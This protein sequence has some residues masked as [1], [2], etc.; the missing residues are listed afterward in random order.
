M[1]LQILPAHPLRALNWRRV[2][3]ITLTLV[4]W[5]CAFIWLAFLVG[6]WL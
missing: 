5:A 6:V 2:G 4:F 1:S 3:A